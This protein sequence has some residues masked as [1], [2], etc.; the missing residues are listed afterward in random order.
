MNRNI[1]EAIEVALILFQATPHFVFHPDVSYFTPNV[2]TDGE[3]WPTLTDSKKIAHASQA[4]TET[5]VPDTATPAS[6]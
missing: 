3:E 2:L 4:L 6:V 5:A 1:G